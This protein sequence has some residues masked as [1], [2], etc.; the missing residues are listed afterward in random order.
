MRNYVETF[1]CYSTYNVVYKVFTQTSQCRKYDFVVTFL[2]LV[3][4]KR[5][6]PGALFIHEK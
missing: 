2:V 6:K 1:Q 4:R 3:A 5:D